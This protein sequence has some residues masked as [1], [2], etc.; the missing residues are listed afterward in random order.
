MKFQKT[1]LATAAAA[2]IAASGAAS[3]LSLGQVY[4]TDQKDGSMYIYDQAQLNTDP[5]NATPVKIDL[6]ATSAAAGQPVF[7]GRNHLIAFNNVSGLDPMSRITLAYLHGEIQIRKSSDP[8]TPIYT[9][10][11]PTTANSLHMCGGNT[12]NTE[13]MCSSIGGLELITYSA[14]YATDTYARTAAYP[15]ADLTVSSSLSGKKKSELKKVLRGMDLSGAKP[16][17]NNYSTDNSLIFVTT[18]GTAKGVLVLDASDMSIVNAEANTGV[19]CGLVNSGDGESMWTNAGSNSDADDEYAYRWDY[20]SDA[21]GATARVDLPEDLNGDVHGAQFAGIGGSFLW[22][23]MRLDNKIHV[24]DPDS[25]SIV[26]TIDLAT[27]TGIAN[28]GG[29]VLDRSAFGTRMYMSTRGYQPITAIGGFISADRNPGVNVVGTIF[30]YGAT[31][32]GH[33][34]IRSGELGGVCFTEDHDDG[35]HDHDDPE[36]PEGSTRLDNADPHGLKS[37]NYTSGGF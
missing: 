27:V 21:I 20:S 34:P 3:A 36:C 17:C 11:V 15:I 2:A 8:A 5:A 31:G 9:D 32:I 16:I 28:L 12:A 13:I 19:G 23:L 29:D 24:I 35:D 7:D 4:V 33:A 26:N 1:L 30:G 14:D 10:Q 18:T 6:V 25:A 22:E 37:L